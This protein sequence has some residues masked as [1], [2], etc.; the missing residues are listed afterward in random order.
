MIKKCLTTLLK[1]LSGLSLFL[2]L[3]GFIGITSASAD[4]TA[5]LVAKCDFSEYPFVNSSTCAINAQAVC[6]EIKDGACFMYVA[7]GDGYF[8]YSTPLNVSN[9]GYTVAIE[10][11]AN[12]SYWSYVYNSG[13][14][15]N[16]TNYT[17]NA[18]VYDG[19]VDLEGS[20][21]PLWV[22]N[23]FYNTGQD[24]YLGKATTTHLSNTSK[25][26]IDYSTQKP[27]NYFYKTRGGQYYQWITKFAV[28]DRVLSQAEREYIVDTGNIT[29]SEPPSNN[30]VMYYGND[31]AYGKT[32]ERLSMPV[33]YNVCDD[34]SSTS[35][36]QI[37]LKA[38]STDE[39]LAT[40]NVLNNCSGTITF[41]GIAAAEESSQYAYFS[42]EKDSTE[43][44]KSDQFLFTIYEPLINENNWINSDLSSPIYIDYTTTN[45]TTAKVSYRIFYDNIASTS[46]CLIRKDQNNSKTALCNSS[47][48]TEGL[49]FFNLEIPSAN[50]E[51]SQV[52]SFGLFE[53]NTLLLES[54]SV[55]MNFYKPINNQND[56][57]N[58]FGTSTIGFMGLNTRNIACTDD[59]W[60]SEETY[61]GLNFTKG[62]CTTKKFVLD[63]LFIGNTVVKNFY[64]QAVYAITNIFPFGL[65]GNINNSWQE[66]A[67]KELP[68]DIKWIAPTGDLSFTVP[69]N[70][71]GQGTTTQVV[72]FGDSIF[73]TGDNSIIIFF[74]RIRALS[75]YFLWV[76]F[77]WQLYQ[78]GQKFYTNHFTEDEQV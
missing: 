56:W 68:E 42:I 20:F 21:T 67:T 26:N 16:E 54:P 1:G 32:S 28:Y 60:N 41:N 7:E 34:W 71:T 57:E 69:A 64:N 2:L 8:N 29:P 43:L 17:I 13:Q 75:P 40:A 62:L 19:K 45:T 44:V 33:V 25:W 77:I 39:L 63:T 50:F 14:T 76:G 53:G 66:S 4:L 73:K 5:N 11:N 30:Y 36:F 23:N 61:L 47:A 59:E 18:S 55:M 37:K 65:I 35:T 22:F 52:I 27:E 31:P 78:F 24:I 46:I 9:N 51:T 12:R 38:T 15:I 6:D 74:Q 58:Q 49:N 70:W 72:A 48:L 10:H 3:V